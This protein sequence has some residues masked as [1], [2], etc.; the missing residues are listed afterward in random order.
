MKPVWVWLPGQSE[1][2]RCAKINAHEGRGMFEY[3]KDFQL[4]SGAIAL[5]PIALPLKKKSAVVSANSFGIPLVIHDAAPA[6]FGLDLLLKKHA[7]TDPSILDLMELAP[8]D[9]SGAIAVCDDIEK[10]LARKPHRYDRFCDFLL[11]MQDDARFASSYLNQFANDSTS[12]GGERPKLTMVKDG[13]LW[14]VKLQE[15]GASFYQPHLEY[16]VMDM[17]K[18]VGLT[19]PEIVLDQ[20]GR[21]AIYRIQ[22]FDR[23]GDPSAPTR[24]M[25]AS[26]NTVLA[27]GPHLMPGSALRTYPR[28]SELLGRWV[29]SEAALTASR[30]ELWKR[31]VYNALVGNL[32]DHT[33]NHGLLMQDDGWSLSPLFDVTP[34]RN[35]VGL[36]AMGVVVDGSREATVATLLSAA[37]F[38][39]FEIEAAADWLRSSSAF[40]SGHWE[41]TLR[42]N[43][44]SDREIALYRPAFA[45]SEQVANDP[46][47]VDA[48]VQKSLSAKRRGRPSRQAFPRP[49][50]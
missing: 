49:G 29:R 1:P 36:L 32:D 18:S 7:L 21:H 2:T 11:S 15:R 3:E 31:M 25:Y 39:D 30:Q 28:L 45:F 8:D 33:R 35:Y 41:Q 48:V 6:G 5:D 10:K 44:V 34:A 26:A 42:G 9:G 14:L 40:V 23:E 50:D 47:A 43:G 46:S 37:K 17:A 16:S 38:F 24:K 22:R 13:K 27:A 12:S 20:V 19:V 4:Q